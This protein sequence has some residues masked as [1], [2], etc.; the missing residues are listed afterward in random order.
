MNLPPTL[1]LRAPRRR[2]RLGLTAVSVSAAIITAGAV[3]PQT[4]SAASSCPLLHVFA[5]QGTTESSTTT[6]SKVDS[7][8]LSQVLI[9]VD[10]ALR[11]NKTLID[12]DYVP[13]PASFG[14]RAGDK[15]TDTYTQSVETGIANTNKLISSVHSSCPSTRV[16][17]MGYSQGA[18]VAHNVIANIGAGKGPIPADMFAAGALFSDPVR[19]QGASLFPGAPNQISPAAVPGTT[20]AA[21]TKVAA[22]AQVPSTG[23]GIAPVQPGETDTQGFGGVSGR[24]TSFCQTGDLACSASDSPVVKLATNISG[25]LHLDQQDPQQTLIDVALALGGTAIRSTATIV[26]D[27]VQTGDGTT[28]GL[29]Y[30]PQKTLLSRVAD[31]SDPQ[32]SAD[33][34]GA[35]VKVGTIAFNTGVAIAKKIITPGNI[36]EL[37][38]VGL[39]NPA[40][41]LILF[42]QKLGSAALEMLPPIGVDQIQ[43]IFF[44]EISQDITDNKSLVNMA[45]DVRYWNTVRLHGSYAST[46]V[47]PTGKA[48]TGFVAQWLES[49]VKDLADNTSLGGSTDSPST[50]DTTTTTTSSTALPAS[51]PDLAPASIGNGADDPRTTSTPVTTTTTTSGQ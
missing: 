43:S 29:Q 46:P 18:H 44:N 2:V 38:T 33:V 35:M 47:T 32:G 16:A 6:N 34:V 42:G 22:D 40:A 7:G 39:A 25:Q 45:T 41:A 50:T 17:I 8:M 51:S 21:V 11:S 36:A 1:R 5:L 3:V 24:V 13:Y 12:R 31:G 37:A 48:P 9:P 28:A 10:N 19:Q 20:G 30:T 26:N 4:A 15:S 23:G 14:G 49:A 27:D